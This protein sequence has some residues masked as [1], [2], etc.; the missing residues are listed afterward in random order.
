MWGRRQTKLDPSSGAMFLVLFIVSGEF[1]SALIRTKEIKIDSF[2]PFLSIL[3]EVV[4]NV[5]YWTFIKWV[6]IILSRKMN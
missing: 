6:V 5:W 1:K 2:C 4:K 3:I